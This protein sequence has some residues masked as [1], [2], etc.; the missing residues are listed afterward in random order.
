[1][2]TDELP[3]GVF[4]AGKIDTLA[5]MDMEVDEAR[6][7]IGKISIVRP[8][9]RLTLDAGDAAGLGDD[10]AAHPAGRRQDMA[11]GRGDGGRGHGNYP[12]RAASMAA[13]RT[14]LLSPYFARRTAG[15]RP[16][17]SR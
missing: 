2:K 7:D 13:P 11:L 6:Q 17:S 15:G 5:A 10:A 4:A 9:N 3:Y 14:P 16:P 1:M 8:V 12:F